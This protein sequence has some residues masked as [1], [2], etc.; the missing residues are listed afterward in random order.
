[1]GNRDLICWKCKY[2]TIAKGCEA[3]PLG[4]IPYI[5]TSENEHSKPLEGQNNNL[6][7][8]PRDKDFIDPLES[9]FE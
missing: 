6:V 5:V 9:L 8:T 3:F 1:M 7:F 4:E 2:Y